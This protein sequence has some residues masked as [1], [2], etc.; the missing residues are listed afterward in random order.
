MLNVHIQAQNQTRQVLYITPFVFDIT[1]NRSDFDDILKKLKT[2]KSENLRS[3]LNLGFWTLNFEPNSKTY[4]RNNYILFIFIG[5]IGTS[6]QKFS[7][8]NFNQYL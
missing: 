7:I 8:F 3:V 5:V 1:Y 4:R 2:W 6:L